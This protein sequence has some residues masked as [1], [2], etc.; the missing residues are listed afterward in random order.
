M[1]RKCAFIVFAFFLPFCAISQRTSVYTEA[2]AN[3][4]KGLEFF[5]LGVYGMA[6]AEFEKVLDQVNP[7]NEPEYRIIKTKA[8]L[9]YARCAVRLQEPDGQK[10]MLEFARKHR[11]D[12]AANK[13][14]LELADHY[15]NGK[16]YDEAI[17]FFAMMDQRGFSAEE[18]ADIAFKHAYSL[19]ARKRYDESK[20]KFAQLMS[21]PGDHYYA[22]YYYHG[23]ASFHGKD[24]D[25]AI[26]SWQV[27]EKRSK[28]RNIIPYYI[29]QIYFAQE[30]FEQVIAYAEPQLSNNRLKQRTEMHQLV[31]QA[32]FELGNYEHALSYLEY[33]ESKSRRLREEDFYQLGLV[34]YK[35]AK[36]ESAIKSFRQ[37][38]KSNSALGQSAMFYLADAYLKID[39][40]ASARN[41]FHKVSKAKFD[42][43][44]RE[45]ALFNFAKLSAELHFD[46][47]AVNTLQRFEPTSRY[48]AQAQELLSETLINTRDYKR[49]IKI[50]ER[51]DDHSP[52]IKE[53]YQKVCYYQG[54]EDYVATRH[55][56]ALQYF[57]KSLKVPVDPRIQALATFWTGEIHHFQKQYDVSKADFDKY[58]LL[59]KGLHDLPPT[60]SMGAA[61]YTQ[62]Y[63]YLKT[64]DFNTALKNFESSIGQIQR[65]G[66][67]SEVLSNRILPDAVLRAGDC[68]FKRNKYNLAL[69]YYNKAISIEAPGFQYALFQKA[70]IQG[71]QG[72][73]AG[74]IAALRDLVEDHPNSAYADDALLELGN[75]YQEQGRFEEALDPLQQLVSTY[76]GRSELINSA[77]LKL[78]LISYNL[79]ELDR[80]LGY[81]K[82]IFK[83]NPTSQEA[84]DA[85]AAIEEIYVEDLGQPDEYVAFV[86]SLPGYKVSGGERDSLNY[87]VALRLYEN[88]EYARA[89][90]AFTDYLTRYPRGFHAL[91]AVYNRAECNSI[92][93][94]FDPALADYQALIEK[95][96]S[97]YYLPSLEKAALIS[98]NHAEAFDQAYRYYS[99]LE[100]LTTD[101]ETKFTAQLGSMRSAYR[102]GKS[103]AASMYASKVMSNPLARQEELTVA[104]FYRGKILF[105][106]KDYAEALRLFELVI[107]Q[108]DN[109]NTAEA[110]YLR[111]YIAYVSRDLD[112]AEAHCRTA[113]A[114]S[115]AYPFWVAKSLIL[116]SDVLVD[117]EDFFNAKAALEA[118]IDNFTDDPEL[119][120]IAQAKV[121]QINKEEERR[122]RIDDGAGED[123]TLN[124]N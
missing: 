81:Y 111:A 92:L 45:E 18:K 34:Q 5:D 104:Q 73:T 8:E 14:L 106:K 7:V 118:V 64:A 89:V 69:D 47:D 83:S 95:G 88:A 50:I 67:G 58:V 63:N 94:T 1:M 29:A 44:M 65:Y 112:Q 86:E 19:F 102:S 15:Y 38:D 123:S 10:L 99:L 60:A 23:L 26:A 74:K 32:Y 33:Y 119:V 108:S 72:R 21:E 75:T 70:V 114:E 98:Y 113:Y 22:S 25:D 48:Y 37:L 110:R 27:A 124:G 77:Y 49:A 31:G 17:E 36:Y 41:A 82:A 79:G 87:L 55:R 13:A 90:D 35:N 11:P 120:Q 96:Q 9:Y 51:L 54:L 78:G 61:H 53:A 46:R 116:L 2:N 4:K 56:E 91:D 93:K 84:K 42:E 122:N 97:R 12:P 39:D 105:E 80:A 59:A 115:G 30:D 24:Y 100:D 3:F 101:P 52:R 28:Y 109:E 40:K 43:D 16:Q 66:S 117:K 71:L 57:A 107:N 62:G 68:H 121:D 76:K 85:L 20:A 6:Q 103:E